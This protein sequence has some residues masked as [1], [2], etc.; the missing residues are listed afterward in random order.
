MA[1]QTHFGNESG[2]IPS[3]QLSKHLASLVEISVNGLLSQ[4]HEIKILICNILV[5]DLG[6]VN[7]QDFLVGRE[8]TQNMNC[9][10][11][12]HSHCLV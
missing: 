7:W 2:N 3:T 11:G 10:V 12:A 5:Q 4:D 9:F 1:E 6:D 8:I